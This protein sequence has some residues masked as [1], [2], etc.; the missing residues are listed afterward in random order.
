MQEWVSSGHLRNG[1]DISHDVLH[2]GGA[3][4][5]DQQLL[6]VVVG[7][8][9]ESW[10]VSALALPFRLSLHEDQS[11]ACAMLPLLPDERNAGGMPMLAAKEM[12][13]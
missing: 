4:N 5:A 7:G 3:A 1:G 11:E 10:L 9:E 12:K 2:L 8:D 13:G 6:G